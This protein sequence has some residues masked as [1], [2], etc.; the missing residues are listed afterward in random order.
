[1]P[2]TVFNSDEKVTDA[3]RIYADSRSIVSAAATL[4]VGV[5]TLG[6][7]LRKHGAMRMRG[8][9]HK[10]AFNEDYFATIDTEAKAYWLG[11]IY[12]DGNVR[13]NKTGAWSF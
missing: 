12:A 4:G 8:P 9:R 11:F 7:L 2:P 1:M 3:L 6:R 13:K 5:S 10:I